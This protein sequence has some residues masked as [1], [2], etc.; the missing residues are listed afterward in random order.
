MKTIFSVLT[1][2]IIFLE[3]CTKCNS[4]TDHLTVSQKAFANFKP[5]SY[6]IMKDSASGV[7]DSFVVVSTGGGI[8]DKAGKSIKCADKRED[9]SISIEEYNNQVKIDTAAWNMKFFGGG[10]YFV[11]FNWALNE[12]GAPSFGF[13]VSLDEMD[14]RNVIVNGVSYDSVF[15]G[16][17]FAHPRLK[18]LKIIASDTVVWELERAHIIN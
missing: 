8:G 4:T 11:L 10:D 7:I 9:F 14:N 2:F 1:L 18:L 3:A 15:V 17:V 12:H 6:W 16:K 5:G 13:K